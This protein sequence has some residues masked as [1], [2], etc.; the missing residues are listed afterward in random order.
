MEDAGQGIS[1]MTDAIS[2]D[3]E[4]ESFPSFDDRSC[5]PSTEDY[6]DFLEYSDG[7]FEE[8]W[9]RS[10][11]GTAEEESIKWLNIVKNAR[12][13]F[14]SGAKNENE[15]TFIKEFFP[16]VFDNEFDDFSKQCW[17]EARIDYMKQFSSH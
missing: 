12:L 13:G 16:G 4:T 5:S 11:K 14:L 9:D 7:K 17:E 6:E 8:D 2:E 15:R 10:T 3:D 1:D